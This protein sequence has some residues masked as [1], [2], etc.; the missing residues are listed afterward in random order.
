MTVQEAIKAMDFYKQKLFNGIFNQ[1]IKAFDVAKEAL[2]KQIPKKPLKVKGECYSRD[3][4]GNEGYEVLYRC[5]RC[6]SQVLVNPLPC[7]CGQ[8]IDW[9][10][11]GK[12]DWS[13]ENE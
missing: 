5:P 9:E 6:K 3:I 11:L 1:Y 4:E 13:E 7:E 2:E 12:L 8:K 10:G